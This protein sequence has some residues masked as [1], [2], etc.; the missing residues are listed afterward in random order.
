MG[1]CSL[2]SG[3]PTPSPHTYIRI[4]K[5]N[6]KKIE[7]TPTNENWCARWPRHSTQ[8]HRYQSFGKFDKK[9]FFISRT[10][11]SPPIGGGR[12][13]GEKT[14]TFAKIST[15]AGTPILDDQFLDPLL[16]SREKFSNYIFR[17]FFRTNL[18]KKKKKNSN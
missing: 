15:R 8:T 11:S 5:P 4:R 13:F 3:S 1:P 14:R 16:S 7:L 17:N 12:I 2:D 6:K 9:N 10:S 18:T